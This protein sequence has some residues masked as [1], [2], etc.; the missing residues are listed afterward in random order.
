MISSLLA[1]TVYAAVLERPAIRSVEFAAQNV[2][3]PAGSEIEGAYSPELFPHMTEPLDCYDN[4]DVAELTIEGA[5]RT[6]KTV[7]IQVAVAKHAKLDPRRCAF[8]D[9]D[10][11]GV[12]RVLGRTWQI[13]DRVPNL[14]V[15]DPKRRNNLSIEFGGFS[16]IG[17][18]ARSVSS[19]AD[20]PASHIFLNEIDKFPNPNTGDV[21]Q[22]SDF[23]EL[24]SQR[25]AGYLRSKVVRVCTPTLVHQSRIDRYRA[26]GDNRQRYVP[27]PHCGHFQRLKIGNGKE[28]GGIR[29]EKLNG[30]SN[31]DKAK[32]T[33]WYE[34]EKCCAKILDHH[35]FDMMNAGVWVKE[36]ES[37]NSRGRIVGKALKSPTHASFQIST[38]YSLLPVVNWGWI[39]YRWVKAVKARS[40]SKLQH[41]FNSILGEVFDPQPVTVLPHE[42]VE[43]LSVEAP[44]R[45][46]PEWGR[47]VTL[48]ADVGALSNE[49]IFHWGSAAWGYEAKTKK[50][51]GQ[52]IERGVIYGEAD[53]A[54][55]AR[56]YSVPHADGGQALRPVRTGADSGAGTM[57]K[58]V[59][60]LK[61]IIG[62]YFFAMK[63]S[64]KS[65]FPGM[66]KPTFMREGLSN[67]ELK[68]KQQSQQW[69]LVLMNT[70]KT[71]EW[72]ENLVTGATKRGEDDWFGIPLEW[73][74]NPDFLDQLLADFKDERG[75]WEERGP[76]EGRDM[77]RGNRTLA[78]VY[79]R[80]DTLWMKLP[81]RRLIVPASPKSIEV[82]KERFVP[83]GAIVPH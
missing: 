13:L 50:R 65:D 19:A 60:D 64:S 31:A 76:N 36:G 69:D 71:Q 67:E 1:P 18:W 11:R 25:A 77:L 12:K 27:C 59:A 83:G 39:A 82:S 22:E 5:S 14:E 15:P 30:E 45:L 75:R 70:E 35:R 7:V 46:V 29:Y 44:S 61:K 57:S 79:T 81:P 2:L 68:H 80:N 37:I 66:F 51:L 48:Y 56:G 54:K 58:R 43:R 26:A 74:Q 47:F 73:C 24:L 28:R 21:K 49:L 4:P 63:G 16:L 33:A 52:L 62:P 9:A 78:S 23:D 41:F 17:A 72:I 3:M 38:L 53:F 32:E 40:K 20:F 8:G 34:C 6:G 10:I 42:L 55:F